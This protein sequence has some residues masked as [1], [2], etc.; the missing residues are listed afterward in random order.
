MLTCAVTVDPGDFPAAFERALALLGYEEWRKRQAAEYRRQWTNHKTALTEAIHRVLPALGR[1][2]ILTGRV[3]V[4]GDHGRSGVAGCGAATVSG[5]GVGA[6]GR[7]AVGG[8]VGA[9]VGRASV[10]RVGMVD[11]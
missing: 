7:G 4:P 8:L 3:H 6:A 11:Q 1:D 5:R 9:V 2:P 10:G